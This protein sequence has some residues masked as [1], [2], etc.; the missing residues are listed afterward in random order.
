MGYLFAAY[1]I[2]WTFLAGYIYKLHK[3]QNT[4]FDEIERLKSRLESGSG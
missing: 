4:L 2:F 1:L 3:K